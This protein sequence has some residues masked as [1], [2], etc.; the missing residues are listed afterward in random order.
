MIGVMLGVAALIVVMSVMHGFH[1]ELTSNIIGL[2][3]EIKIIPRIGTDDDILNMIRS[4]SNVKI[5]VPTISTKALVIGKNYSSGVVLKGIDYGDLVLKHHIVDNIQLG[6]IKNFENDM[7]GAVIGAELASA[8]HVRIGDKINIVT[9]NTVSTFLGAIPRSKKFTV[10]A[11]FASGMYDYDSGVVIISRESMSKLISSNKINQIEVHLQER[12]KM[13]ETAL[14]LEYQLGSNYSV[15]TWIDNNM[16]LLHSLKIE[17]VAMFTI[18][19]LIILVAA[20]NI[21]SSLFMLVNEKMHD[22]AILRTIGASRMQIM[23]AFMIS[24]S[25]IGVIGTIMGVVLGVGFSLNIENIRL[26]LESLTDTK[27][28]EAA[29]YYLYHLPSHVIPEDIMIVSVLS[30]ILCVVA[31]IYPAYRASLLNPADAMRY[32]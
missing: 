18:L 27:I 16:Q 24:G 14:L 11:I 9:I 15:S 7:F 32:E 30:M 3:G 25:M 17:R 12:D 10:S 22:I 31:T 13:D 20:F 8:L 6:D 21:V 2:G 19:S 23:F 29:L 26:F 5:I 4:E 1:D 28:F